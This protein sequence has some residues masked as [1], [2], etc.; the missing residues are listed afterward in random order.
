MIPNGFWII[1]VEV[2]DGVISMC[3]D[4]DMV[5]TSLNLG[6]LKCTTD[7]LTA[8]YALQKRVSS[9]KKELT[10]K[11]EAEQLPK[12]Y[13]GKWETFGDYPAWEYLENSPFCEKAVS[14][15]E[16]LYGEKP[17]VTGVHAG[18]ECGILAEK[19]PGLEAVSIGPNILDIH[20]T[21]EKLDLPVSIR[22]W[23]FILGVLAKKD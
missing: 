14:A 20:T 1:F 23:D 18:L 15:Y 12:T 3:D 10:R 22:T 5:Q 4:I 16:E 17:V 2:P 6:I 21:R 7:G 11:S 8:D 9:E 13:G 19:I